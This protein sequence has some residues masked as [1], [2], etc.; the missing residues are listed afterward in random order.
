MRRAL[1]VLSLLA[2]AASATRG[3]G[4]AEFTSPTPES[5][6]NVS[7]W[8]VVEG[9]FENTRAAGAYRFF[10]SPRRQ[11][12]YQLMRYR[13]TFRAPVTEEERQ[14]RPTEKLVWNQHPGERAPLLCWERVVPTDSAPAY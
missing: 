1:F 9:R 11:A 2:G 12:L 7:A 13:V 4:L 8:E 14:N 3:D 5:V 10:V 6:D